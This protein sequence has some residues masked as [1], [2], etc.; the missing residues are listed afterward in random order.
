VPVAFFVGEGAAMIVAS[1]LAPD[2]QPPQRLLDRAVGQTKP[3]L[4]E[5]GHDPVHLGQALCAPRG[6]RV[7]LEPRVGQRGAV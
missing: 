1:T 7:L 2:G 5:V 6:L 3:I 4:E